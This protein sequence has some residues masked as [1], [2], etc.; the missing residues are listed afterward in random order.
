M[1]ADGPDL[2]EVYRRMLMIRL[3]ELRL[4][5]L[6]ADGEV[7]GFIHLSVGQE[8]V[9]AGVGS[10]LRTTDTIASTHR[11][12][13]HA[14]AK[15][16]GLDDFFLELMAKEEGICRGRGGS[17]HVASMAVGMLGANAIVGASIPIA[18]GSALAHQLRGTDAVAVAYF[19]DG[20]MA[21]GVLHESLNLAALWS[22]P[23]LFVCENNGWAEFSP[24][25]RQFVAPLVKLAEAFAIPH[26][27][28][29]GNDAL[30]VIAAAGAAVADIRAGGGPR[31]V[32]CIT[33]R[34]RGHYEGDPQKYRDE[35]E[36]AVLGTYDPL[37]RMEAA[38]KDRGIAEAEIAAIRAEVAEEVERAVERGR[39]GHEPSWMSASTDVYAAAGRA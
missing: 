8:A 39:A 6:F 36:I 9:A 19:G 15:G 16:I 29:D 24:T 28:I 38:M 25:S 23:L 10:V 20:A 7:P 18:L 22:L 37:P 33:H 27:R 13:G 21:E 14:L 34:W 3:V 12:H 5:R 1:S 2:L 32:E 17:M 35:S 4:S 11:G 31:V 30:A 26:V